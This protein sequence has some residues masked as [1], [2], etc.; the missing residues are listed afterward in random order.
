M[1]RNELVVPYSPNQKNVINWLLQQWWK[2]VWATALWIILTFQA[3]SQDN[4]PDRIA[5][6][7]SPAPE[8]YTSS[9][10]IPQNRQTAWIQIYSDWWD[11]NNNVIIEVRNNNSPRQVKNTISA[12]WTYWTNPST[13]SNAEYQDSVVYMW[14]NNTGTNQ[15]WTNTWADNIFSADSDNIFDD[16]KCVSEAIPT[17]LTRVSIDA[18]VKEGKIRVDA[19]IAQARNV[20]RIEMQ[21]WLRPKELAVVDSKKVENGE[22]PQTFNFEMPIDEFIKQHNITSPTVVYVRL[23][24]HDNDWLTQ[25]TKLQA[26]EIHPDGTLQRIPAFPNPWTGSEIKF[27]VPG[28]AQTAHIF[29]LLTIDGKLIWQKTF[30]GWV[31]NLS[32][33]WDVQPGVHV[34]IDQGSGKSQ[35]LVILPQ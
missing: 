3:Q 27:V 8:W 20:D 10:V 13:F 4:L 22:A 9:K 15:C 24:S 29:K 34:L 1:K 17:P 26:V 31:H 14:M 5:W 33:L 19:E 12:S 11:W 6:Q 30:G 35:K 2:V 16:S 32:E 7:P 18:Y 23:E 28:D 25:A 21:A